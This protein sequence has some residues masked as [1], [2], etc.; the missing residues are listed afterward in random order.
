MLPLSV[1]LISDGRPGHY[2]LSDGIVAAAA[3]L[4]P[5]ETRRL[6]VRRHRW[7]PGRVLAALIEGGLA[8]VRLFTLGYGIDARA[9]PRADLVV[10]AGGDTL[11]A[12]AAAARLLGAPN[13][14]YGSLR[15]FRPDDFAL[16]LTSHAR[17]RDRPRHV[18][19]L[20]PSAIDPDSIPPAARASDQDAPA[21]LGLLVGGDTETVRFTPADWARLIAFVRAMTA[22]TGARWL[23][24]NSRRT[25]R[26]ATDA[27]A[28]L[29]HEPASPIL[30][31]IDV[32]SAGAGTLVPLFARAEAVLVTVDSSSM[33][34][35][36]VW[37]RRPVIAISPEASSLPE[38]EQGYRDYL[39]ANG[40]ASALPIAELTSDGV[41][42]EIAR[43]RPLDE[44]PL[45]VLAA[46]LAEKLPA[47]F[48]QREGRVRA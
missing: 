31:F 13:I 25:P 29:A 21:T 30:S 8:P 17:F 35:E 39:A 14:F 45:D 12:N 27:L 16:V 46:I 40:W 42:A 48:P 43:L 18:V 7:A 28:A 23:V 5:V 34:S 2:H 15:Q 47:L 3:R 32:H 6:E 26:E 33:V 11:A 9:L 44:H 1:L 19:T 37:V 38:S 20:K 10:S 22:K 24:S 41:G 36:A 4:R